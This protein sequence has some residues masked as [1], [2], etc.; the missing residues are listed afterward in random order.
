MMQGGKFSIGA[1]SEVEEPPKKKRGRRKRDADG[2]EICSSPEP[3]PH[4][5]NKFPFDPVYQRYN[6]NNFGIKNY[7]G[8]TYR[9]E[10]YDKYVDF[11]QKLYQKSLEK[12][13]IPPK[14]MCY[15]FA[16]TGEC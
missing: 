8:D 7:L 13:A 10:A 6:K 1:P 3:P 2:N 11:G 15:Q 9:Q 5:D 12:E 14:G 16:Y 4:P